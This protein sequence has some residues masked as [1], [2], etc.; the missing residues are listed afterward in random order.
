MFSNPD[1]SH[2]HSLKTLELLYEYDDFMSSVDTL[3]DFGC[4]TGLDLEW[5]ATRTT[6]DEKPVPLNIKCVGIDTLSELSVAKKYVNIQYHPQNFEQPIKLQRSKYDVAWCHNSFQYA[7]T[8]LAT[9]ANWWH[10]MSENGMLIISVPQTT[11]M[12]FN[13]QAFDQRSYCY[14]HWTLVSLIHALAVSGFDCS[15]GFFNKGIDDPWITAAVYRSD[16]GPLDP[17]TTSWYHLSDAG[18]LPES[19]VDSI[20]SYGFLKQRDLVLPWLDK[21]ITWY[22]RY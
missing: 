13:T 18:L 5:W 1:F 11:N 8:P 9:L 3:V 20:N 17:R 15:S 14:H 22:G 2:R 19:A 21:S 16:Q 7:I 10:V 12:E 6:R 4:G